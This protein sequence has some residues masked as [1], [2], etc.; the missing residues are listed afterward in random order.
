[1]KKRYLFIPLLLTPLMLSSC[2]FSDIIVINPIK[3]V[4]ISDATEYY[5]YGDVYSRE[6]QL[7]ITVLNKNGKT[8]QIDESKLTLTVEVDGEEQDYNT[9]F[10]NKGGNGKLTIYATYSSVKSNVLSYNLI[11]EHVYVE[12]ISISGD[13]SAST[14]EEV[15]LSFVV[16]PAN[17]TK[18]VN[19]TASDTSMV[20]I[21][22]NGETLKV[23]GKKPGEVDIIASSIGANG[24]TIQATHHMNFLTST[25]LVTAKQT[26]N[27]FVNHNTYNISACPLTG[28]PKLLVIP[29]WFTDSSS[30]ITSN[31]RKEN[32]KEDIEKVYFGS[33]EETGWHSVAS[34]YKEESKNKL[35]LTGTVSDWY[36]ADVTYRQAGDEN[37]DTSGLVEKAVKWFF[38]NNPSENRESY[39][40]DGDY[41]LDGVMLIYAAPDHQ[42]L[43]KDKEYPNLWAYCYWIQPDAPASRYYPNVYF[44]A[45]YDFIYG[46]NT[47]KAKTGSNYYNGDTM[48]CN[49]DAHTYI[50]EMGHV[51]GLEDYY[52]YSGEYNPAGSF[53]MQDYNVAGHDP[54]SVFAFGWASAYIPQESDT[55]TISNFQDNHDLILLTPEFN[56]YGSPFDE[57]L[58]LELYTPTGLNTLDSTYKYQ[59]GLTVV[60]SKEAGIRLW[61]VDARLA[62]PTSSRGDNYRLAG[63]NVKQGATWGI[64]H[65]FSNTYEG[66]D[67]EGYLSVLGRGNYDYNILQLIRNDSSSTYRPGSNDYFTEASL[68]KKGD[69]FEMSAYS[70]QFVKGNKLNSGVDLGW[71]FTVNDITLVNGQYTASIAINKI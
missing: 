31:T 25:K 45:S 64:C 37:F 56:S 15:T 66:K 5:A 28:S 20:D 68:F 24:S 42:A 60:G 59:G 36:N 41:V 21:V 62:T 11:N 26:Y 51:F 18:K 29:V 50:H 10:Q 8:E 1:M 16:N 67:A 54:F 49:L 38:D 34:Y 13:S 32:V 55:I 44:W 58:L 2:S 53:S 3:S 4:T 48:H 35:Q 39:D 12:S 22:V 6:Q 70:K 71:S 27:D 40:S 9:A 17:H 33:E 30:F 19:V 57:Y 7:S 52:D 46:S 14:Y 47:A 61:H 65:A 23:T 69:T 43:G 63:S